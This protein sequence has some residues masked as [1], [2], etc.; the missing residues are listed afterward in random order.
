M[1]QSPVTI[2]QQ[3]DT[4]HRKRSLKIIL[5]NYLDQQVPQSSL[6]RANR[7]TLWPMQTY[8]QH[9]GLSGRS[10]QKETALFKETCHLSPTC[11]LAVFV[12]YGLLILLVLCPETKLN[13]PCLFLLS[14]YRPEATFNAEMRITEQLLERR[15][16][17]PLAVKE[18]LRRSMCGPTSHES[19]L[20]P[21]FVFKAPT[22]LKPLNCGFCKVKT[23][24]WLPQKT[25]F[26]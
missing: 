3:T 2:L 22:V 11:P 9:R 5:F 8:A 26:I 15:T 24:A 10:C 18:A 20:R 12:I 19:Q 7:Y 25:R 4:E 14:N 1:V 23:V 17:W 21:C 16:F 6:S 13:T